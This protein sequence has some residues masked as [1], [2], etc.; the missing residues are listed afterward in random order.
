MRPGA[1][2]SSLNSRRSLR[3]KKLHALPNRSLARLPW[4]DPDAASKPD[5][6]G[7]PAGAVGPCDFPDVLHQITAYGA[8]GTNRSTTTYSYDPAANQAGNDGARLGK[9][10]SISYP[11]TNRTQS[12]GNTGQ[13]R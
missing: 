3:A 8:A 2:G 12:I 7:A 5:Y 1:P 6:W 10:L 13:E 9:P 4:T 11:P